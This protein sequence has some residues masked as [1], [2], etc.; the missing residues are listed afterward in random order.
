[1]SYQA[2]QQAGKNVSAR[3]AVITMSDTRTPETDKSG[4]AIRRLLQDAGHTIAAYA[5]CRDDPAELEPLA[6]NQEQGDDDHL[7]D[8]LHVGKPR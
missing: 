1:M 6:P 8:F 2:H 5:I 4:A 7:D 3:C